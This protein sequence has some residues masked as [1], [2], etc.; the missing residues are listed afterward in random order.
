MRDQSIH[1]GPV[2]DNGTHYS[3]D[4]YARRA[5][6][7]TPW[8]RHDPYPAEPPSTCGVCRRRFAPDETR[9][10]S[11]TDTMIDTRTGY[12]FRRHIRVVCAGCIEPE[13]ARY[14]AEHRRPPRIPLS[15]RNPWWELR[16]GETDTDWARRKMAEWDCHRCRGCGVQLRVFNGSVMDWDEREKHLVCS[17]SCRDEGRRAARR[18]PRSSAACEGCGRQFQQARADARYC[19]S[20]CRQRAYRQRHEIG[21][22]HADR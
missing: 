13:I 10:L 8:R 20:V 18:R 7:P 14:G 22:D 19:S 2:T 6:T 9:W 16:P 12:W 11:Q 15:L 17:R 3:L 21:G 4:Y 5:V 1:N